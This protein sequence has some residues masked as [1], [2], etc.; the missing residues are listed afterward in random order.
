MRPPQ[1]APPA[2]RG[3]GAVPFAHPVAIPDGHP[4]PAL[5]GG[6]LKRGFVGALLGSGSPR[7]LPNGVCAIHSAPFSLRRSPCAL[8]SGGELRQP[9]GEAPDSAGWRRAPGTSRSGGQELEE[10]SL[11]RAEKRTGHLHVGAKPPPVPAKPGSAPQQGDRA[12]QRWGHAQLCRGDALGTEPLLPPPGAS[13]DGSPSPGW[14]G[15][16]TAAALGAAVEETGEQQHL[17]TS[18]MHKMPAAT[19]G[20]RDQKQE[21]RISQSFLMVF[22]Y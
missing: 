6:T 3:H 7:S 5:L 2:G 8:R 11:A 21:N 9:R 20:E 14:C 10:K 22:F 12:A 17:G 13:P 4:R 15:S 1:P 16:G 18:I 19:K